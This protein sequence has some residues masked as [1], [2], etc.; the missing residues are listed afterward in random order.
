MVLPHAPQRVAYVP[1]HR[2]SVSGNDIRHPIGKTSKTKT[3][4]AHEVLA[5]TLTPPSVY[6][7]IGNATTKITVRIATL[8]GK[9]SQEMTTPIER[10]FFVNKQTRHDFRRTTRN[11]K[12]EHSEMP[13]I[14]LECRLGHQASFPQHRITG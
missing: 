12:P 14:E 8:T 11:T 7:P 1:T 5:N 9:T 13:S 10:G 2:S 3:Q 4:K 6:K